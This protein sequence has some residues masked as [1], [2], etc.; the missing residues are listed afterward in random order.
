MVGRER[1]SRSAGTWSARRPAE[2]AVGAGRRLESPA[3]R[4]GYE[5]AYLRGGEAYEAFR[6]GFVGGRLEHHGVRAGLGPPSHGFGHHLRVAGHPT[7][8][9]WMA[10]FPPPFG[11]QPLGAVRSG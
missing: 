1:R 7:L 4:S 6:I 10:P 8:V 5:W 11:C 9:R 3:L 2:P